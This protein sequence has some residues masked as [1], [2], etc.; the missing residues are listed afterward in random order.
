MRVPSAHLA[1]NFEAGLTY[2]TDLTKAATSRNGTAARNPGMTEIRMSPV[3][4][5]V[6]AKSGSRWTSIA[7]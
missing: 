4:G 1:G 7:T 3:N 6:I 2:L 5:W